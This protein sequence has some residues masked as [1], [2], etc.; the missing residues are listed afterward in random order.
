MGSKKALEVIR[1]LQERQIIPIARAQMRIRVVMPAKEAKR[2]KEKLMA[3]LV[4]SSTE[5]EDW[6]D[7]YELVSRL[8]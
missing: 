6:S 2:V 1:Q 3:L 8:L 4:G 7:N 5:E